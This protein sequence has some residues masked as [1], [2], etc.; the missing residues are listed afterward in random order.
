MTESE[1]TYTLAQLQAMNRAELENA[2]PQK[3]PRWVA[4]GYKVNVNALLRACILAVKELHLPMIDDS[5]CR[6]KW[7]N[8]IKAI[9]LVADPERI[10]NP[11]LKRGYMGV[12]E[13][14]L[15]DMVREGVVT[16]ADLGINDF[17]TMK[18]IFND[19]QCAMCWTDVL[20]FVEKDAAFVH[21]KPLSAFFNINIIS[22]GGWAHTA[23]LERLLRELKQKGINEVVVFTVG[24]YDPF[25]FAIEN[26]FGSTCQKLGLYVKEHHRIGINPCHATPEILE[27]QKYPIE[28]GRKLSVNGICFDSDRWLNEYGIDRQ[29]GLEIEAISG[30]AGGHQRLREIVAEELLK[31]LKESDRIEEL[32]KIAW[33]NAALATVL[34]VLRSVDPEFAFTTEI[35]TQLPKE[36]PTEFLTKPEYQKFIEPIE[37]QKDEATAEIDNEISDAEDAVTELESQREKIAEPFDD[38]LYD[39]QEQYEQ[40]LKWLAHSLYRYYIEHKDKWP[41]EA[42]DLGYPKGCLLEAVKNQTDF[43]SFREHVNISAFHDELANTLVS[44]M[45]NGDLIETMNKVSGEVTEAE[46]HD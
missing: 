29:Y 39:L 42:Y 14:I 8:P 41:R 30:Q 5:G 33:E 24:D 3:R 1:T 22:G 17:R 35:V 27:V 9:V 11:N 15:S 37:E 13:G 40:S 32:T 31:Y 36:L 12:F 34:N 28:H 26:E 10:N 23:G 6:E 45:G 4:Q 21:L 43:Y 16:Y 7:Y 18:Q 38:Q 2:F 25:G 46:T 19:V 44:V 20:L